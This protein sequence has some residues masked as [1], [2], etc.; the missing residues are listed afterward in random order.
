MANDGADRYDVKAAAGWSRTRR[1]GSQYD[2]ETDR[3]A[4]LA[5]QFVAARYGCTVDTDAYLSGD[6]GYDF[7]FRTVRVDVIH[8]GV[9]RDGQW[10]TANSNII[11]NPGHPKLEASDVLVYVVNA[12][13]AFAIHG[14]VRTS[15][16]VQ[17]AVLRDLG[18]GKKLCLHARS[19]YVQPIEAVLPR[20]KASW[21]TSKDMTW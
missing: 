12:P 8:A 16:F 1:D 4:L 14:A 20:Q 9:D 7:I 6:K 15:D 21:L 17:R 11:V 18:F 3:V 13:D 10:R 5:E 19:Q 2:R